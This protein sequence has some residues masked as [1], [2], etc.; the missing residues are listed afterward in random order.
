MIRAAA[1][2]IPRP[3]GYR[4]EHGEPPG[5]DSRCDSELPLAR[6]P[7]QQLWPGPLSDSIADIG[8]LPRTAAVMALAKLGSA[9]T[10]SE[11]ATGPALRAPTTTLCC[12]V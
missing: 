5:A 7:S 8:R 10:W 1:A 2:P 4:S 12:W 6:L 11:I 3:P 9:R